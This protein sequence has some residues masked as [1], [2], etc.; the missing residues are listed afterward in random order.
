MSE[1]LRPGYQ[2]LLITEKNVDGC[3]TDVTCPVTVSSELLDD[4]HLAEL[5]AAFAALKAEM[6]DYDTD[7][8]ITEACDRTFGY[9][10]WAFE[11]ST[12]IEF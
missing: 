8:F 3:G 5:E 6:E 7:E 11:E 12:Y 4:S 10:N 1:H 9:G 2:L